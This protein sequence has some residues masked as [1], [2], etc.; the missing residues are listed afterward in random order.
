M[1]EEKLPVESDET[2]PV[3]ARGQSVGVINERKL[4]RKID[5]RILPGLGVLLLLS[6]L[7]QGNG[8]LFPSFPSLA[9]A[10]FFS[11]GNAR[12]EG[13]LADTHMSTYL[14]G[15]HATSARL[16]SQF[17]TSWKSI[18]YGTGRLLRWWYTIPG[19]MHPRPQVHLSTILAS[20]SHS[21]VG[22]HL[23]PHGSYPKLRGIRHRPCIFG[24]CT[25]RIL[26]WSRVLSE[27]VV[28]AKRTT[29]SPRFDNLHRQYWWCIWR[30]VCKLCS[31][32][33]LGGAH[34]TSGIRPC[35]DEGNRGLRWMEVDLHNR[36]YFSAG[37]RH[38]A[39]STVLGGFVDRRHSCRC[40]FLH[41]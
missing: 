30:V 33:P 3:E 15:I 13:L 1:S 5:L 12:I 4:L 10:H 34:N 7:D 16:S 21:R 17:K 35:Q 6:F 41:L 38:G 14:L 36:E 20:D 19:S 22:H 18:P 25:K 8:I 24:Y 37:S 26:F 2:S 23:H 9:S 32:L 29:L 11:V 28:Q 31:T 40:L 39:N 27:H